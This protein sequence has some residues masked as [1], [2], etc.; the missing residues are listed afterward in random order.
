MKGRGKLWVWGLAW[1]TQACQTQEPP[2]GI[3]FFL[4][5]VIWWLFVVLKNKK[6]KITMIIV[7]PKTI[8]TITTVTLALG[9][10]KGIAKPGTGG[11]ERGEEA[12][13]EL[14]GELFLAATERGT[15]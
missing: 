11:A 3:E 7:A 6:T 10:L 9:L 15:P 12:A 1:Q 4:F 13:E 14:A 5:Y 8:S 2:A